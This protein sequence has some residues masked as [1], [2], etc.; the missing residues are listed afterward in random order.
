MNQP[1]TPQTDLERLK[2]AMLQRGISQQDLA[3]QMGVSESQI[4]LKLNG[5]RPISTE[6]R[7]AFAKA[8]D[9][10]VAAIFMESEND[11]S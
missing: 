6:D 4:S 7:E 2:L 9:L 8:L 1:I 10:Q 5:R 11:N 3:D